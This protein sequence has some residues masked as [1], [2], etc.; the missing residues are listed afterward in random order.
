MSRYINT[1]ISQHYK[2]IVTLRVYGDVKPAVTIAASMDRHAMG[3]A[4]Y[5]SRGAII[6]YNA[7]FRGGY[8][9]RGL[10]NKGDVY[11]RKYGMYTLAVCNASSKRQNLLCDQN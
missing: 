3:E 2:I 6:A 8:Y 10:L 5:Y 11:S 1:T 7:V 9:S 4:T